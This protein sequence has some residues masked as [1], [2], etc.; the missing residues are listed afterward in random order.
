MQS[1]TNGSD[2]GQAICLC[3]DTFHLE[4]ARLHC[5]KAFI[6]H[7]KQKKKTKKENKKGKV[8]NEKL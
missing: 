5:L 2:L 7:G 3:H 8:R 4:K 6:L 1:L